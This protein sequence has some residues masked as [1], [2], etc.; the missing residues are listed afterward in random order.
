M[1]AE[2]A[3]IEM[4]PS[5]LPGEDFVDTADTVATAISDSAGTTAAEDPILSLAEYYG[6]YIE[7]IPAQS[8]TTITPDST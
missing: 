8:S 1:P 7:T 6:Y 2:A 4:G 5:L 3:S